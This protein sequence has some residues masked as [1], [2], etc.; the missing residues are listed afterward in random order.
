LEISRQKVLPKLAKAAE[1]DE[2]QQ[3]FEKSSTCT[4]T[5]EAYV[6]AEI[7]EPD[8]KSGSIQSSD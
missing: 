2:L 6:T 8:P 7:G 3:L 5:L 1:D 4:T